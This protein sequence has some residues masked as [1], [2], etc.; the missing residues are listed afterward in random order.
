MQLAHATMLSS[1]EGRIQDLLIILPNL[2][3]EVSEQ[4]YEEVVSLFDAQGTVY[5]FLLLD[6]PSRLLFEFETNRDGGR[7]GSRPQTD[8]KEVM[9][10]IIDLRPTM[11]FRSLMRNWQHEVNLIKQG[12]ALMY[13][14]WAQDPFV[15]KTWGDACLLL[16]P[17]HTQRMSY[18]FLPMEL[19]A[20]PGTRCLVQPCQ[21]Y[22]EGGNV[23]RGM[24]HVIL[25]KDLL[26]INQDLRAE[27]IAQEAPLTYRANVAR[28]Q[29]FAVREFAEALGVE[30]A[31]VL[32]LGAETAAPKYTGPREEEK[33][34][35]QP[36][37]HIDLYLTLGGWYD[38]RQAQELAFVASPS[39]ADALLAGTKAGERCQVSHAT[40]Q[41]RFDG[42]ATQLAG[43]GYQVVRLPILLLGGLCYSWNN[44][45]I[46]VDGDFRRVT[47]ASYQVPDDQDKH[48][49]LNSSL[50]RVEAQVQA[51]YEAYGFV[52][53]WLR[54]DRYGTFRS[55]V[56][57]RGGLHCITKVLR[58]TTTA[59]APAH[60]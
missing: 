22:L 21:L 53:H 34:S 29:P 24:R 4:E 52:V 50:A 9:R 30:E 1:V 37:F 51:T 42:A 36:L 27:M 43:A 28:H 15:V 45:L 13:E 31:E 49:Q 41:A 33:T 7:G 17:V 57:Q 60:T 19:A 59:P 10:D 12:N 23:L 39:L 44:C 40:W 8:P 55:V 3:N 18:H 2:A 54:E 47:L 26:R 14:R 20:H 16:Q 56:R 35:Y 11:D 46:E 38:N 6:T 58:R 32:V 25:G 48:D 5:R